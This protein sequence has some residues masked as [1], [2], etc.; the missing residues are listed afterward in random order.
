M[1][2]SSL[3]MIEPATASIA[4]YLLSNTNKI[5]PTVLKKEP[6]YYKKKMCK[7]IKKNKHLILEIGMDEFSD[8]IFD[9]TNNI[10]IPVPMIAITLYWILLIIFIL[11]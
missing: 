11:I 2:I 4:I 9:I 6:F 8:F 10:H 3:R 7:W 1:F 5:K